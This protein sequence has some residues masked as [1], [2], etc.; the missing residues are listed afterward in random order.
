MNSRLLARLTRMILYSF[1]QTFWIP[2]VVV[3][4]QILGLPIWSIG[5]L[6]KLLVELPNSRTH[7]LEADK[8]G[9]KL[10]GRACYDP[11]EAIRFWERFESINQSPPEFL[12][13]H[14]T[15]KRRI[16]LAR[17]ELP[18]ALEERQKHFC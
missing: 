9:L 7:E 2:F 12:S 15:N 17:K 18:V 6:G 13:T 10:M 4:S 14:P 1:Q 3:F 5:P 8:V 16:E 11:T